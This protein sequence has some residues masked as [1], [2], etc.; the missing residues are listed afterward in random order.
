LTTAAIKQRL[1]AWLDRG[2]GRIGR[3]LQAI[4]TAFIVVS[5]VSFFLSTDR[6]L[7]ERHRQ[8]FQVVEAIAVG[9]F[10]VE[11][12]LRLWAASVL[13]PRG[14]LLR[15]GV[16]A[17]LRYLGSFFGVIDLAAILP[18]YVHLLVGGTFGVDL[19]FLRITRVL[20]LARYSVALQIIAGAFRRRG[21]ELASFFTIV[22]LVLVMAG[23]IIWIFE[24]RA[25][26]DSFGSIP[27]TL[28]WAIVTMTT[29]GYGDA[30]PVTALG[31]VFAGFVMLTGVGVIAVPTGL[32]GAALS[33]EFAA[34]KALGGDPATCPTCGQ[35]RPHHRPDGGPGR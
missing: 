27:K 12:V 29:V 30:Y 2:E 19:R 8:A 24:H 25:Q 16:L 23:S 10:S 15:A 5:V 3:V 35:S 14:G 26:P 11:Y 13:E 21:R 17:R 6:V 33:E 32:I 4:V 7:F 31:K 34:R 22:L 20:K 9:V 18:F 1:L 28:W